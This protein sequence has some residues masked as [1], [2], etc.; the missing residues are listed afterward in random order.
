MSYLSTSK[1]VD[2]E[3]SE[4]RGTPPKSPYSEV[5]QFVCRTLTPLSP[6]AS[7]F[8]G[9]DG[10]TNEE[11]VKL[12]QEVTKMYDEEN[13][14][15][16]ND[17]HPQE[18]QV[19]NEQQKTVQQNGNESISDRNWPIDDDHNPCSFKD[20]TDDKFSVQNSSIHRS[21]RPMDEVL[22]NE[23]KF[24]PKNTSKKSNSRRITFIL[25]INGDD[26]FDVSIEYADDDHF[27]NFLLPCG[28]ENESDRNILFLNNHWQW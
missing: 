18:E 8:S 10:V 26:L 1:R 22:I 14:K 21:F 9:I 7:Q 27:S 28:P 11:A 4:V 13:E 12:L 17:S 2:M 25:F 5:G 19:A 6:V 20:V 24:V 16:N 23:E 3:Q 15:N